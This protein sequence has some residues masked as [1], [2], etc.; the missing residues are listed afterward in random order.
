VIKREDFFFRLGKRKNTKNVI[1]KNRIG[2]FWKGG[3]NVWYLG[4]KAGLF[5]SFPLARVDWGDERKRLAIIWR[6][7]RLRDVR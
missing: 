6:L 4:G 3:F 7:D 1:E 2:H 5:F